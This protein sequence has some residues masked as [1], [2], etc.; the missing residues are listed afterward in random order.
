MDTPVVQLSCEFRYE[1]AHRLPYVPDAHQCGRM[2]G[3]S[4][5][6]TVDIAGPVQHDGFV[7]DFAQVKSVVAP[8]IKQ[9]DHHTLN[10]IEGL[11]NPTVEVQ[12]VWFW[13]KLSDALTGLS[14]LHLRETANHSATYRG[15]HK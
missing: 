3:H 13:E 14:A 6:L 8:L 2:H 1:A 5:H 4:Y 10:D 15:E 12:L 9:L 11:D 7:M